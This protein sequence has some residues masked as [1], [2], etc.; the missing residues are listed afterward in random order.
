MAFHIQLLLRSNT[1]VCLH[2]L[3]PS[4]ALIS[5]DND[6]I[7][8]LH[9]VISTV[10]KGHLPI[11]LA[12]GDAGAQ[13]RFINSTNNSDNNK[14]NNY[15]NKSGSSVCQSAFDATVNNANMCQSNRMRMVMHSGVPQV[16]SLNQRI[17]AATFIYPMYKFFYSRIGDNEGIR[18]RLLKCVIQEF[19]NSRNL[20]FSSTLF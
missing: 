19:R 11:K 10:T 8:L 17:Q 9:K 12:R 6:A 13:L 14:N 16:I 7:D 15:K 20:F 18:K 1:A 2:Y 4:L 3:I 5:T